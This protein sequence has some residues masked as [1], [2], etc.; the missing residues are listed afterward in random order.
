MFYSKAEN[1]KRGLPSYALGRKRLAPLSWLK[2]DKGPRAPSVYIPI[3]T[4]ERRLVKTP[5]P[6]TL[7]SLQKQGR[8]LGRLP[9]CS[10]SNIRWSG[11]LW[12][13]IVRA[14]WMGTLRP[15]CPRSDKPFLSTQLVD[16]DE[17]GLGPGYNTISY[18]RHNLFAGSTSSILEKLL[19]EPADQSHRFN[20]G[21]IV[22]TLGDPQQSVLRRVGYMLGGSPLSSKLCRGYRDLQSE[23]ILRIEALQAKSWS[24]FVCRLPRNL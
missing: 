13:E 18:L 10:N 14:L 20:S 23:G 7:Q 8:Y 2:E 22:T 21:H 12:E 15:A 9:F 3:R 11:R 19:F 4:D 1:R 16:L 5:R 6:S 24:L 17:M